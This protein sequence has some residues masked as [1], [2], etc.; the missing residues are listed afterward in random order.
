MKPTSGNS[1]IVRPS[2]LTKDITT[3]AVTIDNG[4]TIGS[5]GSIFYVERKTVRNISEKFFVTELYRSLDVVTSLK[6]L[7]KKTIKR[8]F[9]ADENLEEA[10]QDADSNNM[11]IICAT[12]ANDLHLI[13]VKNNHNDNPDTTAKLKTIH[14]PR[15]SVTV[16]PLV[17]KGNR[18]TR[19]KTEFKIYN[20]SLYFCN[21]EYSSDDKQMITEMKQN[22]N[23]CYNSE[24]K[25]TRK[26][27]YFTADQVENQTPVRDTSPPKGNRK[28][29]VTKKYIGRIKL[30]K[31][32]KQVHQYHFSKECG[33]KG[34]IDMGGIANFTCDS[35]EK[36]LYV[37]TVNGEVHV[38]NVKS[39][40]H[41]GVL[42]LGKLE[43]DDVKKLKYQRDSIFKKKKGRKKSK[44]QS[45]RS[46]INSSDSNSES[47][48]GK[49]LKSGIKFLF[50]FFRKK[51]LWD[52]NWERG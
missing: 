11:I 2:N 23:T 25:N 46:K 24:K 6:I 5:N 20:T 19:L 47:H 8:I 4:L 52:R 40:N 51:I 26:Y 10:S 37:L 30:D 28:S 27:S 33:F 45:S 17:T 38:F 14:K 9:T 3:G 36:Y 31:K 7:N 13:K 18:F 32:D 43:D 49:V 35:K 42:D 12:S 1:Q 50:V 48:E 29:I 16:E 21:T 44:F 41:C 39:Y 15:L 34:M 22:M